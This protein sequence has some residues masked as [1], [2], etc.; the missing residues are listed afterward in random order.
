MLTDNTEA[1]NT[2]VSGGQ[3]NSASTAA[4]VHTDRTL[5][6]FSR[7]IMP[8]RAGKPKKTSIARLITASVRPR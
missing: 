1:R 8:T 7:M 5:I 6:V 2:R 4:T 3:A